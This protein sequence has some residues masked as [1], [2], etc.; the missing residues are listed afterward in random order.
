MIFH[1]ILHV[2]A[3]KFCRFKKRYLII[4]FTFILFKLLFISFQFQS[5]QFKDIIKLKRY[6]EKLN[7]SINTQTYLNDYKLNKEKTFNELLSRSNLYKIRVKNKRKLNKKQN[8]FLVLEYTKFFYS[9]K[10]CHLFNNFN[11]NQTLHELYLN[12]CPFKNCKF[13]CDKSL[14]LKADALL[15]Y[16]Y[17]LVAESSENTYYLKNFYSSHV[18]R[19][20]QVWILWNDEPNEMSHILDRYKM[21]WTMSFRL[22]SEVN[23]CAYGCTYSKVKRSQID[24]LKETFKKEF[25]SRK[26]RAVWFVSNCLAS[27]RLNF[28]IDLLKHFAFNIHGKCK[29]Y[30]KFRQ[31]YNLSYSMYTWIK[32]FTDLVW[33]VFSLSNKQEDK[34]ARNSACELKELN[35]NKFYLSFESKNCTDYITEK[36]WRV[37]N[38]QMIPIVI[39]PAK[40]YYDLVLPKDSYIHAQDFDFSAAKLGDYL[41]LVSNDFE[42]YLKHHLW[43]LD[44]DVVYSGKQCEKRRLCELCTKLNKEKDLIYYDSVSKWFNRGCFKS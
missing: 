35:E 31:N 1:N 16:D 40:K 19:K 2:I 25:D 9:T 36:M 18:K 39:Q 28:G 5:S 17:D 8:E 12:E 29:D 43:R 38:A 37:L 24:L 22:D 20:N 23:D 33:F 15:F 3:Y 14:A 27:F 34:C 7:D 42:T 44:Y 13:T 11:D 6:L 32:Y 41:A 4:G 10:Y 30:F 21:N 26:N